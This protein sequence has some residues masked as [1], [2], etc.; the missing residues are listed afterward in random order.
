MAKRGIWK[1]ALLLVVLMWFFGA[2]AGKV[3]NMQVASP[4]EA[5]IAPPEGKAV[6]VFLRPS[7]TSYM[8][9]SSVFEVR[10]NDLSLVGIVAARAKAAYTLDPGKHLFMVA[11]EEADFMS[12]DLLPNKTYYVLISS[13]TAAGRADL[14]KMDIKL[15]LEPVHKDRLNSP[16][17]TKWLDAC[18]WVEKT[19]A[20]ESWATKSMPSIK[21][22]QA[23][24]YQKWMSKSE[25]ERPALLPGDGR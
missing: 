17:F 8:L 5:R 25:A 6:V 2:C 15:W 24:Y 4:E 14:R 9:Q 12:A 22:K 10:E 16:E 21:I 13:K 11:A 18:T 23:E 7:K 19:P 20:S 3:R 1:A